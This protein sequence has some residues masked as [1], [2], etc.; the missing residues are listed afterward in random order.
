VGFRVEQAAISETSVSPVGRK[1][2]GGE[3][4]GGSTCGLVLWFILVD[5]VE[6]EDARGASA[7]CGVGVGI[8]DGPLSLVER[9]EADGDE[10][11]DGPACWLASCFVAVGVGGASA[12]C[13]PRAAR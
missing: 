8:P 12:A 1:A 9:K 11:A 2:G 6:V 10:R 7:A 3:G 13:G 4:A 5:V